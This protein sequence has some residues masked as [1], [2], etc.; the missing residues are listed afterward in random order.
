MPRHRETPLLYW[1]QQLYGI[2]TLVLY[3]SPLSLK[4]DRTGNHCH[5]L[6][7]PVFKVCQP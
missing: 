4:P 6:L 2:F 1:V 3:R 5:R 7:L